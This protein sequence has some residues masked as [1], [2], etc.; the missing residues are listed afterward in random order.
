MNHKKKRPR[1]ARA[2]CKLCKPHKRDRKTA[3]KLRDRRRDEPK[4]AW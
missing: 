1:R 3:H 2:G 4:G